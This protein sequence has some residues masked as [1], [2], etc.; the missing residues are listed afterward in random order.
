MVDFTVDCFNLLL[1]P[2][3]SLLSY[4]FGFPEWV[5]DKKESMS[6]SPKSEA[7]D[8]ARVYTSRVRPSNHE[9]R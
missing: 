7:V 5:C 3:V 8:G 6:K 2:I 9:S 1:I 4:E